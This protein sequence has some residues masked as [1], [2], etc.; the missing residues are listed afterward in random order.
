MIELVFSSF[1]TESSADYVTVYDGDSTS[2]P[3]IGRF[4]GSSLPASIKSSSNRLYVRFYSDGSVQY[5]GFVAHYQ[6]IAGIKVKCH[7]VIFQVH[8]P[9]CS[10]LLGAQH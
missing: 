2:S 9:L 1:Y 10:L 3:V 8:M 4:S 5:R 6:G 7:L